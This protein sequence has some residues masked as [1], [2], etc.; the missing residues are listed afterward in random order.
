MKA[1]KDHTIMTLD[2]VHY[3]PTEMILA[4]LS[5]VSRPVLL[6]LSRQVDDVT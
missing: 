3:S 2:T 6:H 5:S 4:K 1:N